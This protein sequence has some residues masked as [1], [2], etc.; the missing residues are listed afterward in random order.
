MIFVIHSVK[1]KN[2][3]QPTKVKNFQKVAMKWQ[4]PVMLALHSLPTKQLTNSCSAQRRSQ[5]HLQAAR[6]GYDISS[7][8]QATS[9]RNY[10]ISVSG[11]AEAALLA[12]G[13]RRW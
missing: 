13:R 12:R 9:C 5:H 1:D 11:K 2:S 6:V 10:R 3:L 4:V 7:T 8:M